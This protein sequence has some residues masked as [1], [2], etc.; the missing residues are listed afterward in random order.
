MKRAKPAKRRDRAFGRSPYERYG[1]TEYQY[2]A[3][4]QTW[5]LQF[6]P[7]KYSQERSARGHQ[8]ERLAK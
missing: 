6:R 7:R 2:S 1:K 8:Q 4:Y 3:D 5:A